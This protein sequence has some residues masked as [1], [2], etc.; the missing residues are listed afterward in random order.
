MKIAGYRNLLQ[1]YND[2]KNTYMANQLSEAPEVIVPVQLPPTPLQP[3]P[4]PVVADAPAKALDDKPQVIDQDAIMDDILIKDD[5]V[6]IVPTP[7]P[8]P[9]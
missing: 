5:P 6:V 8:V 3:E 4:V 2:F 9:V 1:L 7:A